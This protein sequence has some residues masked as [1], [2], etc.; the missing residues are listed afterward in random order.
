MVEFYVKYDKT[1][2]QNKV[3]GSLKIP[4]A[5]LVKNQSSGM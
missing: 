1:E 4:T 3:T 5:L 2:K